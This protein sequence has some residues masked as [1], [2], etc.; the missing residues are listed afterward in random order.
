MKM[1]VSNKNSVTTELSGYCWPVLTSLEGNLHVKSQGCLSDVRKALTPK[2]CND[3]CTSIIFCMY[4]QVT[5]SI[6]LTRITNDSETWLL[7][8]N[9]QL[10][11]I[12][13][14]NKKQTA[15]KGIFSGDSPN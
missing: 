15:T 13:A 9:K 12:T 2:R 14:A 8:N 10:F 7:V 5:L 6:K 3:T 11:Y 1:Y 4:H